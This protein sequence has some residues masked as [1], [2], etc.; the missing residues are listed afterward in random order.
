MSELETTY[1]FVFVLTYMNPHVTGGSAYRAEGLVDYFFN[2]IEYKFELVAEADL[3][4][5]E[6]LLWG[7]ERVAVVE[8]IPTLNEATLNEVQQLDSNDYR[9]F[10]ISFNG[11][12]YVKDI[13]RVTNP[14]SLN[15]NF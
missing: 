11:N 9:L 3:N 6:S 8:S 4:N 7:L 10:Y 2:I 1:G 14:S 12:I 5:G 15:L 13:Q